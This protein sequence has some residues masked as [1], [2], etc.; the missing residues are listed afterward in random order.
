ML[1]II[2]NQS[3]Y[4]R[5]YEMK[6]MKKKIPYKFYYHSEQIDFREKDQIKG[7]ILSGGLGDP[8][9]PL[10]LTTNFVALNN[11]EVPIVGLCLGHEIIAVAFGSS[12]D[13]LGGF[14]Q[15]KQKIVIDMPDDPLFKN[16]TE[17][18]IYL[19]EKHQ[20]YVTEVPRDFVTLA[21]SEVCSIEIMRHKTRPIYGFQGHPEVSGPIGN[22]LM[23]NF[24]EMCGF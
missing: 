7:I 21:H 24:L 11:F 23:D 12:T 20:Y 17:K 22:M 2:D 14:Q 1:L 6:L 10:N 3:I 15:K 19:Q 8:Y 16:I 9:Q 18:E 5:S 4:I 13:T